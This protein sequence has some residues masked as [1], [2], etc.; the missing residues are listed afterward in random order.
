[1]PTP[2][3]LIRLL[4]SPSES[5][6]IEYK[7]WL[8]LTDNAGKAVLAKAAIALANEGG[9]IIVL[10]M[11]E[12]EAHGRAL[13]SLPRPP[14]M[15]RYTQDI[16]NAAINRFADPQFHCELA[17]AEFPDTG[18]EHAFVVVPGGLTVPV[19]SIRGCEGVISSQRC[20]VR[21]SGPRSEEPF[22]SEE[23]RKVLERCLHARRE[24]M[25]DA[26]RVIVQGHGAPQLIQQTEQNALLQFCDSARARWQALVADL[27][28]DDPARMPFGR[29]EIAFEF[30]GVV[31]ANSVTELRA[32]MEEAARIKHTGW[33][34]FV[35]LTR[36]PFSPKPVSGNVE[37]W[38]VE[39]NEPRD[40]AH[41]DFWLAHPSGKLFQVRGYDEDSSERFAPGEIID[42][43]LPI[44][45]VGDAMLFAS[46]L[47]RLFD[48]NDPDIVVQCRYEG[49]RNRRLDSLQRL[50]TFSYH[51][52]CAN[53]SIELQA[54][55]NA[56]EM[57][58]NVV[59]VLHQFLKPL[60]E[61]FDFYELNLDMV[62]REIEQL[63]R[64]RF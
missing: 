34:P 50:R 27:P 30:V 58:E 43:T 52:I 37:A 38:I 6:S 19:M 51:R 48:H 63:R 31:P 46:R 14:E 55:A 26:I 33:S 1:M 15:P 13:N 23:W 57:D 49:L 35:M 56:R 16:I 5:P 21:K 20:Y 18:H 4:Y 7:S 53:D 41:S 9:G 3:E 64:H 10:G 12:A 62:R 32:R 44:W 36:E 40:S 17:F 11:R 25:L 24:S 54:R 45:R 28:A 8:D 60:Y 29:Y 39:P 59:E 42:V 2:D 61:Q 47:A 22:T